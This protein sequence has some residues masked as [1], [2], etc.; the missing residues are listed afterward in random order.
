MMPSAARSSM[1]RQQSP[2]FA[3]THTYSAPCGMRASYPA[4]R[5]APTSVFRRRR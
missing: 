4:D 2:D 5:S 3:R 1:S